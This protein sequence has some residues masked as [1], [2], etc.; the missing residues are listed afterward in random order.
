MEKKNNYIVAIAG[1][2]N[3]GKTTL[4]NDLTGSNQK[5]G[6]WSGVTVERKEGTMTINDLSL[7]IIDLPGI[8]GL[9]AY[10][11]DEIV[12]RNF[13][14]H[15][16]PDLV[17]VIVD[18]TNLE[19]N[20]YLVLELIELEKNV[21]VALNMIDELE[22]MGIDIDEKG[23]GNQ[24]GIDMVPICASKR[25]GIDSL[26]EK[27]YANLKISK[28][29]RI[30]GNF[31]KSPLKETI[32]EIE[33]I[34][35]NL[36]G[37][38][39]YPL[40]WLATK[41]I[42]REED[43]LNELLSKSYLKNEIQIKIDQL[44]NNLEKKSKE[45]STV[46]IADYR[47][48]YLH[49]I[50]KEFTKHHHKSINRR[51][52]TDKLDTFF[53][54]RWLG[55]PI[56]FIILWLTFQL[57][58]FVGDIFV[59][60]L[61]EFIT[62]LNTSV[63]MSLS[64]NVSDVF[65]SFLTNGVIGG[66]GSVITFLPN[67]FMLF[68]IIA[69]LESSGYMSRGAFVMDKIMHNM[70]L[71]GKSFIP[72]FM[73]FGCTVPAIMA[74]RT[75]NSKKDR[76]ITIL[77]TPFMSCSARLPIYILF[78][79]IFFPGHQGTVI[80]SMYFIG[81]AV[82]I[83]MGKIFKSTLFNEETAPLVMELPPYRLPSIKYIFKDAFDNSWSFLKRA[84]TV[85]FIGVIIIWCL[86]FLP[87]GV[88]F[89]SEYSAAGYLGKAISP[90]FTPLGFGNWQ[91]SVSLLFGASAKEIVVGTMGTLFSNEGVVEGL[92]SIFTPLSAYSFIVFT[93]LYVPCFGSLITIKKEIGLKWSLFTAFYTTTVAY[94]ISLLIYQIG[95]LII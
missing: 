86:A 25:I 67:I 45:E 62:F 26:K 52:L 9:N 87:A 66:V 54:N 28:T 42:E 63:T 41:I 12:A 1:N 82:A 17:V 76:Y 56:F 4:F 24:L 18:S 43:I 53:T 13:L 40:K 35:K 3:V 36:P 50:V 22:E 84:G 7:K 94:I 90:I 38:E 74:S 2:P 27:I 73:G 59:N 69:I 71:H 10:S 30:N 8:Y 85:I 72:L 29:A 92:K 93:L 14:I 65:L 49:G 57:T 48:A 19:R 68:F 34:L 88:E 91:S 75:L 20:L 47:Y 81:I 21:V 55:I 83:I 39:K 31:L 78:A 60:Y 16:N 33:E 6:N 51:D 23:L 70:G 64:G 15:N 44:I 77:V 80:I 37:S 32:E 11:Q 79:S 46:I 58:F 5:V 89:G 61:E 95:S